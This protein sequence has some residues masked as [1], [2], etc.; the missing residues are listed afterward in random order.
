[1][2]SI[3]GAA[4]VGLFSTAWRLVAKRRAGERD[5]K[6]A[7]SD[8]DP[9]LEC[10]LLQMS[11]LSQVRMKQRAQDL[12][13]VGFERRQQGY[14]AS[15]RELDYVLRC[16]SVAPELRQR[17]LA[18]LMYTLRCEVERQDLSQLMKRSATPPLASHLAETSPRNA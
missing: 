10:F 17:W 15:E 16:H 6:D 1:M 4:V 2:A 5:V 9:D 12:S 7:R 14:E 18:T 3:S 11:V 13:A 8:Y